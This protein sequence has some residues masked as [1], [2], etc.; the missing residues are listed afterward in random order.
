MRLQR[1]KTALE[2]TTPQ[3]LW[4]LICLPVVLLVMGVIFDYTSMFDVREYILPSEHCKYGCELSYTLYN[5]FGVIPIN[6]IQVATS[7]TERGSD[8]HT[9]EGQSIWGFDDVFRTNDQT[10]CPDGLLSDVTA[11]VLQSDRPTTSWCADFS[12]YSAH[13]IGTLAGLALDT[14]SPELDAR[15]QSINAVIHVPPF[16]SKEHTQLVTQFVVVSPLYADVRTVLQIVLIC[17]TVI[18]LVAFC[19]AVEKAKETSH[20][21]YIPEQ[22]CNESMLWLCAVPLLTAVAMPR[23][24]VLQGHAMLP[25]DLGEPCGGL[26]VCSGTRAAFERGQHTRSTGSSLLPLHSGKDMR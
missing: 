5:R 4:G 19:R 22:V 6:Y 3:V 25:A 23:T 14:P 7:I 15:V 24:A 12:Y 21:F 17:L 9:T 26:S 10:T 2:N 16:H 20:Y 8:R 1:Q 11:S 13:A 18:L